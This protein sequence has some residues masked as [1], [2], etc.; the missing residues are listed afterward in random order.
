ME[1]AVVKTAGRV[2]AVL[3]YFQERKQPAS[4]RQISEHFG[5]PHSSTSALLKSMERLGY[6]SYDRK[7][8]SFFPTVRVA[9]LGEWIYETIFSNGEIISLLEKL[10]EKTGETIVLAAQHDI[11]VHFMHALQGIHPIQLYLSAGARRLLCNSGAGWAILSTHDDE[12]I[13]RIYERTVAS[14]R[15]KRT[16]MEISLEQ[17]MQR[18]QECRKRGYAFS[19]GIVP[20]AGVIAMPLP[21]TAHG[22]RFAVGVAGI[23]ERLDRNEQA[24]VLALRSTLKAYTR[25]RGGRAPASRL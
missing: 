21:D 24:M 5:Y 9:M 25:G 12:E 11:Y 7:L 13:V 3:E 14:L 19:R 15:A 2:F 10:R 18:I 22:S 8:R 16:K 4:V 20:G 17:L 6:L 23:L 1:T